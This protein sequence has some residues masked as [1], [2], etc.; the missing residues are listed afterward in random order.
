[1]QKIIFHLK[2]TFLAA[3]LALQKTLPFIKGNL[4][5][6]LLFSFVA[7]GFQHY[8]LFMGKLSANATS[9]N[10]TAQIGEL[11][12]TLLSLVFYAI[13]V[14]LRL[15]ENPQKS[16]EGFWSFTIRQG[17]PYFL[18]NIRVLGK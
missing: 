11:S 1:M 15:Q 4:S 5:L 13:L 10:L 8:F 16:H 18:E 3:N 12:S 7:E 14:S 6:I 17:K 2:L 9:L